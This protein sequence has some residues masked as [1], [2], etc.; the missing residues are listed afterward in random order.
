MP[1][2]FLLQAQLFRIQKADLKSLAL[3]ESDGGEVDYQRR[4]PS[5]IVQ[6]LLEKYVSFYDILERDWNQDDVPRG[7]EEDIWT[8]CL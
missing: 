6:S 3:A 1:L 2:Q 4:M 8:N 7:T 5:I